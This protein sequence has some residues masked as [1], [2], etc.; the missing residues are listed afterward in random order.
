MAENYL[1][2]LRAAAKAAGVPWRDVLATKNEL[3]AIEAERRRFSDEARR[4]AWELFCHW[5]RTAGCHAFWRCGWEHVR[6]HLENSGR[7]WSHI[8]SGDVLAESLRH[9]FPEVG[10]WTAG[11][12]FA[13]LFEPY[14][15]WPSRR[16]FYAEA[17]ERLQSA[18][19]TTQEATDGW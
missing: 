15:R 3:L 6:R 9:E 5:N 2:E 7:D 16:E 13:W 14:R 4:R 12:I 17:L 18:T 19:D 8:R 1:T 11:E 10:E